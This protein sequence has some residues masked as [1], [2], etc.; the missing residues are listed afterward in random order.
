MGAGAVGLG[1]AVGTVL[2]S[3]RGTHEGAL[4]GMVGVAILVNCIAPIFIVYHLGLADDPL[5][6]GESLSLRLTIPFSATLCTFI[7]TQSLPIGGFQASLGSELGNRVGETSLIRKI[8]GGIAGG[9]NV[10]GEVI[11]YL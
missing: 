8:S 6:M 4:N 10:A 9:V 5:D 11:H 3:I 7:F 1:A 2:G